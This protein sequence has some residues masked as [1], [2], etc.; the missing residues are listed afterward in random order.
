MTLRFEEHLVSKEIVEVRRLLGKLKVVGAWYLW[1]SLHQFVWDFVIAITICSQVA[2][3]PSF[4]IPTRV[5][6]AITTASIQ[7]QI[8]MKNRARKRWIEKY[9]KKNEGD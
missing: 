6:L 3:S 5:L 8:V 1:Q 7:M 2:C 9:R 4:V